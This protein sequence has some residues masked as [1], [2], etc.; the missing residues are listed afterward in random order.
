[1]AP[2]LTARRDTAGD[3]GARRATTSRCRS[4][5]CSAPIRRARS[6]P[7]SP[8]RSDRPRFRPMRV[9]VDLTNSPHVLVLR[10]VIEQL[11][12]DG[13]EVQVT[14]RDF[15]QTL[16][17]ATGSGSATPTSASTAARDLADKARGLVGALGR[18]DAMG[19]WAR[20]RSGDR[21]RL[22]RHHGR[23]G[24]VADPVLDDV[25]LRVGD[26]PA[27]RQLPARAGGRRSRRDPARAAG[28]VRRAR[29]AASVRRPQGGVLP[30]RLRA[31][32]RR[33]WPSSGLD[34]AQPI[35]VV[36]TPPVGVAVSPVRERPVRRSA[37]SAL[38]G[39]QAV[40]LPRTPEQRAQLRGRRRLRAP[41]SGDRRPVADRLRGPGRVGG[42]HDEPRGGRAR[43]AGVH[44]VR[45]AA[46]RGRRTADRRRTTGAVAARPSR[47]WSRPARQT[48]GRRRSG[49][50]A[51]RRC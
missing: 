46:R 34:P 41:R 27:Q 13:H 50:A 4:A 51:T 37:S 3:R 44:R 14:A 12:R 23:G 48:P 36:R 29:Q 45:R 31:R 1:M 10:P 39:T 2:Y 7:R 11:R 19:I 47:L 25:R 26:G 22:Q 6:S 30:G 8:P 9:W 21:P 42:R 16:R 49:C 38:R 20:L 40:V 17:C 28:P 43:H 35:V 5:R 32:R 24:A 15:A 33:C 18:A